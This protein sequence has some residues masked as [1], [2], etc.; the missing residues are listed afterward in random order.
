MGMDSRRRG[1]TLVD[2]IVSLA[3]AGILLTIAAP[4]L[5]SARDGRAAVAARD[6]TAGL[7]A[8]AR[9]LAVALGSA[10]V[11]VDPGAS[12]VAL[13]APAGTRIGAAHALGEAFGVTLA[14]D[15]SAGTV[16]LDFDALGMGRLA[17]RTLRFRRGA[18]EA[19]L[20]LSSYGRPRRW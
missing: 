4:R 16:R 8:E 3:I 12:S 9:T 18:E 5:G 6:V 2:L 15:H 20:S 10:V 13:E 17:N 7:V 11:V 1:A 19:R 14:V